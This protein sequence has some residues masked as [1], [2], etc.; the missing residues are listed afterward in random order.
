MVR[1]P[2]T[3]DLQTKCAYVW[4]GLGTCIAP[5]ANGSHSVHR[6]Q[7]LVGFLCKHKE[8]GMRQCSF[9]A[10]GVLSSPQVCGKLTNYAKYVQHVNGT[11]R[12]QQARVY[13]VLS[14]FHIRATLPMLLRNMDSYKGIH[15]TATSVALHT[16][17]YLE[18]HYAEL[19]RCEL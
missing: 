13:K 19:H 14:L 3:N 11:V 4:M 1:G 16:E 7:K 10:P 18:L 15:I 17:T 12:K 9:H 2:L 8:N 6:E 5:S